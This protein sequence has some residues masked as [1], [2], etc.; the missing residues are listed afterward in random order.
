[1]NGINS[2][3][4]EETSDWRDATARFVCDFIPDKRGFY[5]NYWAQVCVPHCIRDNYRASTK[6]IVYAYQP[7]YLA[8]THSLKLR[9]GVLLF[10]SNYQLLRLTESSSNNVLEHFKASVQAVCNEWERLPTLRGEHGT[11][12]TRF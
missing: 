12:N 7:T 2:V 1:M 6:V 3:Y 10:S 11:R 4:Q 5:L 9:F 8:A